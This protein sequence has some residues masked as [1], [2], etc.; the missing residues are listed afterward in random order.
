[1][2]PITNEMLVQI[3][4][5][6]CSCLAER[7]VG[8]RIWKLSIFKDT[9]IKSLKDQFFVD[10]DIRLAETLPAKFYRSTEVYD[11]LREQV[12][13]KTWQCIPDVHLDEQPLS[14]VPFVLLPDFLDEPMVLTRD[15][16]G[17]VRCMSN[18][19]THRGNLVVNKAGPARKLI[20]RY[21]GR[22]FNLNGDL[23]HMPEFENTLNFP[24]ACEHLHSFEVRHWG[25]LRFVG[26]N[27]QYDFKKVLATM[28]ERIG[29][30]NPDAFVEDSSRHKEYMVNANWA[31]YCDNYLEGF[32]IPFVHNAL[33]AV[34]DFGNY[35]TVCFDHLN[36]QIGIANSNDIIFDFP[37]HHID[38]GRKV[39]AYYFWVFPNMMF[40]FYP[41][42]LSLNIVQPLGID[43]T[44]VTFR[45][46]VYDASKLDL[47]A[48]NRLDTV[49]IEDEEVVEG[50]QQGIRSRYYN[51]GRFSPTR[52][53]GVHHF[54]RLLCDFLN[55]Q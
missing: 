35:E 30:M 52:E 31:L 29:F 55:R 24:R 16:E 1:M 53:Q 25:P 6:L 49:E 4:R 15:A 2:L 20:C 48:G 23:E 3:P 7:G 42:G 21:H 19:C 11:A 40:N 50:V 36:L 13:N 39:A 47:G 45:T 43:K 38:F 41:W 37:N 14:A 44:K 5:L 26:L 8:C 32:H 12:F 27:P 18:V 33:D 34:L 10:P 28:N 46:Y 54:H 51:T 9:N 17:E 22:R